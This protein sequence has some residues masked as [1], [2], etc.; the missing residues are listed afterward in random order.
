LKNQAKK[1]GTIWDARQKMTEQI[2]VQNTAENLLSKKNFMEMLVEKIE[3]K[4]P[5]R[6]L[7][8]VHY[9]KGSLSNC[10]S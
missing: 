2:A 7:L 3:Y 5:A 1:C 6:I 4:I 9:G 10:L 8:T